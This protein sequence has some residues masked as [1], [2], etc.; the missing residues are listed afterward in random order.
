M[1]WLVLAA[2]AVATVIVAGLLRS[3][4]KLL[5]VAAFGLGL[6][7]FVERHLHLFA[8]P[9]AWPAWQGFVKGTEIS[10]SDGLALAVL[11]ASASAKSPTAFRLA[12][13]LILFA[14][15]ISTS[16]SGVRMESLFF[17]WEILRGLLVY[18]AVLRATAMDKEVPVYVLTGLIAGLATQALV[19]LSEFA[20]GAVQAGGWFGQQNLLGFTTHFVVYPAFAVFLG[21]Y[22]RKRMLFAVFAGIVIAFTGASRAT[23]GLMIGGICATTAFS[24]WHHRTHRKTAI[25]AGALVATAII[26]PVLYSA[27]QRRSVEQREDSSQERELMKSAASM[28]ISDNPFGVG[29]NRY[30]VV[31]NVGGY[32]QRAG[33]PWDPNNR[34]APVHNS[35]Y[36]VTAEMGWLGLCAL[37]GLLLAA[38]GV[39]VS[40]LRRE[41]QG[42]RGELAAGIAAAMLMVA[43]HSYYEWIFFVHEVLYFL[44]LTLGIVAGL[45]TYVRGR[46]RATL[47]RT[48]ASGDVVRHPPIGPVSA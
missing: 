30:V 5:K 29:A 45:N 41:A 43:V 48:K 15:T 33:V 40:T 24:L 26:S 38:M 47:R 11:V 17:G 35:Y 46:S 12:L 18:L 1:K 4:R 37:I 22:L 14:Y 9:I 19:V 25:I 23:I 28:I 3:D 16:V 2:L 6:L 34:S 8:A 42:I 21:G 31:A 27:V 36:L 32:S 10:A 20:G 44:A 7:P 39:A 13:A